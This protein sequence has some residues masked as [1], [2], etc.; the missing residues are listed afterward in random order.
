GRGRM[1]RF[2]LRHRAGRR[3]R[4]E[5][6]PLGLPIRGSYTSKEIGEDDRRIQ[7]SSRGRLR[8]VPGAGRADDAVA[9]EETGLSAARRDRRGTQ[10][11]GLLQVHRAGADDGESGGRLRPIDRLDY[12]VRRQT[13]LTMPPMRLGRGWLVVSALLAGTV[14]LAQEGFSLFTTDF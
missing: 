7:G 13:I 5:H 12:E 8:H 10:W 3:S 1:R 11:N 4:R 6:Q 14:L 9:R 2:F